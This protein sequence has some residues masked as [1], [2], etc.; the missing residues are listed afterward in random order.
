MTDSPT[1][2][3]VPT[4]D[5][6]AAF[7]DTS[8]P[9]INKLV[10]DNVHV[11]YWS[12]PEDESSLQDATDRMTD[13]VIERLA[14]KPGARVLDVGCGLGAPA[15][16]LAKTA[17]VHVV[18]IATSPNLI[19]AATESARRAGVAEQVTFEVVDAEELS[20]PDESFDAVMAIESLVHMNDRPRAFQ[21]IGR[22]LGPGGRLVLTDRVEITT[23]NERERQVLDAYR[24]LSMNVPFLKLDEYFRCLIDVRLLPIEYRD[25]T[26]ETAAHQLHMLE[27]IERQSAEAGQA[28]DPAVLSAGRA[29]FTDLFEAKLPTNMLL[30]AEL[31]APRD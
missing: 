25:I 12:S 2:S 31:G 21:H 18:G 15:I 26:P 23:P 14:V 24:R 28:L 19:E 9:L 4:K 6:V 11:G 29:V 13:M 22:V 16:R 27:A 7:Y 1:S 8:I 5:D 3:F 30:V 10:G 20:Y 17:D